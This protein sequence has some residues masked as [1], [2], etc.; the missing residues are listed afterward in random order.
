MLNSIFSTKTFL[1]LAA[2]FSSSAQAATSYEFRR[3]VPALVAEQQGVGGSS[4]LGAS[5]LNLDFGSTPANSTKSLQVQ[6]TNTGANWLTFSEAPSV[7]GD[8]AFLASGF[9][10]ATRLSAGAVCQTEISFKSASAGSYQG[11]LKLVTS[12]GVTLVSLKGSAY[13]PVVLASSEPLSAFSGAPFVVNFSSYF[14]VLNESSPNLTEVTWALIG[15]L[16]AG[17]TFNSSTGV[18]SGVPNATSYQDVV[19]SATYKGNTFKQTYSIAVK[20]GGYITL[21]PTGSR[22]YADGTMASSCNGY[23]N[24]VGAY[25]YEGDTGDGLYRVKVG[26]AIVDA[27]CDMTNDGGGWTLVVRA[28]SDSQGHITADSEG[29]LTSPEQSALG[30]YSDA[31]INQLPK[32]IYRVTVGTTSAYFDTSSPFSAVS[33]VD[34]KASKSY[35]T[36]VWQGPFKDAAHLGLNTYQYAVGHYGEP[37]TDGVTYGGLGSCRKGMGGVWCGA[38][39]SGTVWLK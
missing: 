39:S 23:R 27:Y 8:A 30:K 36:I 17:L 15:S 35:S 12:G 5:T 10:C 6:L 24:P 26:G 37:G 28:I 20:D 7:T 18:L 13:N 25:R 3:V 11:S 34:N 33:Q 32:T 31:F 29:Q 14:S 4:Q 19:V 22:S 21:T 9:N 16:P 2:V 38:G 1:L